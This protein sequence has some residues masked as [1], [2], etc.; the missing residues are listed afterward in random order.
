VERESAPRRSRAVLDQELA[1]AH[2]AFWNEQNIQ[3]FWAGKT[4]H[5]PGEGNTLSYSLA[6]I[7]VTLLEENRDDF[8]QFVEHADYHDAGQD[9]ALG[10]LGKS[11]GDAAASFLGPGDWRPNRKTLAML[12]KGRGD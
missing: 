5:Q 6:E 7:L 11:L 3:E 4:F 2:D 1:A 8:L 10:F 9:A 12:F